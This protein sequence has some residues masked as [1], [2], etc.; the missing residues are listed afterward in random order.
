MLKLKLL[1]FLIASFLV[2]CESA[3]VDTLVKCS[4]KDDECM[5]T[6]YQSLIKKL[7]DNG[8]PEIGINKIEPMKLKDSTVSILGVL[9]ITLIEGEVEG[10]T[11]CK[12]T[13]HRVEDSLKKVSLRILCDRFVIRGHYIMEGTG[14]LFKGAGIENDIHGKGNGKIVI[15]KIE[16]HLEIPLRLVKHDDGD[17]YFKP[18][19]E[20]ATYDFNVLGKATFDADNIMIGEKN[21]SEDLL[22]FMN[23]NWKLLLQTFGKTFFDKAIDF[24][25]IFTNKFF[26]NI[27]VKKFILEDLSSYVN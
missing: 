11:S 7:G 4:I 5:K 9:N 16:V 26:E 6:F 12:I 14:A 15:D 1:G 2:F 27:P 22:K 23:E 18:Q 25:H 10:I 21:A 24:V 8:A 17:I 20:E 19:I 3:L 13:H